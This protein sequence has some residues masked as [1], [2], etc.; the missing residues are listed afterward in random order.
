LETSTTPTASR[1]SRDRAAEL[2]EQAR[3]DIAAYAIERA[4]SRLDEASSALGDDTSLEASELTLRI[5]MSRTWGSF[6]SDPEGTRA[7][8][9]R[10]AAEATSSGLHHLVPLA[11]LQQGVLWTRLGEHV[12]A[13]SVLQRIGPYEGLLSLDD[14]VRLLINRGTT[15]SL[16]LRTEEASA[17]LAEAAALAKEAGL[18]RFAYM[19]LHNRGFVEFLRGDLPAAL[20]LM[21]E[22][23]RLDAP[24]DRGIAYLDR[25]RVLIEAGLVTD[26]WETLQ[27]ARTSLAESGL[28]TEADEVELDLA[29]CEV[30]LAR[31]DEAVARLAPLIERFAARAAQFRAIEARVLRA[32]ALAFGTRADGSAEAEALARDAA[33]VDQRLGQLAATLYAESLARTGRAGDAPVR[34]VRSVARSTQLARRCLARRVAVDLALAQGDERAARRTL[35][36]VSDDLRAARRG[37]SSLDLKTGM[38]LHASPLAVTDVALAAGSGSPARVLAVTERWRTATGSMP[39]VRPSDD[40]PEQALWTMLRKLRAEQ[41]DAAHEE[42]T[43]NR[44][45]VSRTVRA[46]RETSWAR[47][48]GRGGDDVPVST[49]Q[50]RTALSE[51]GAALT[52]MAVTGDRLVAVVARPGGRWR[53]VTVQGARDVLELARQ[54]AADLE[55]LAR[56]SSAVQG[57]A[58]RAGV[59]GSLMDTLAM[60]DRALAPAIPAG[61]EP[62]LLV[63]PAQL[64]AL[65]WAMLP[66]LRGRPVTVSLSATH[67]VRHAVAVADPVVR[68]VAGPDLRLAG[69]EQSAVAQAWQVNTPADL[70]DAGQA[71]DGGWSRGHDF[72]EALASADLVHVAAHGQHEPD[73]PLF[74]SLLLADGPTFVHEV[75]GMRIRARHVVLSACRAGRVNV[76]PGDEPLGLTACLLAFGVA[77]VV[78][79]VSIVGDELALTTM[80]AY[81]RALSSGLDAASALAAATGEG[82]LL[83]ASFTCFGAEWRA[84]GT[85][86]RR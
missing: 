18:D 47:D 23:D 14:R 71:R 86:P 49:S 15:A 75:E 24:V 31:G 3:G 20:R 73:N 54:V 55:A 27:T 42:L 74:S 80:T 41:R 26:A 7:T 68:A 69:A 46:L 38:A 9:D 70:G 58:L 85:G 35:R 50:I 8:L 82:P 11:M 63:P 32:E 12:R 84:S 40:P 4:M 5:T 33:A 39:Q 45:A 67:W 1:A 59:T 77:T 6:A 36:A 60:L 61:R 34:A 52:S 57:S 78:A 53:L 29:R 37:V 16:L 56:V 28:E 44:R 17:D 13:L 72:R 48:L 64:A 66:S 2:Y 25:G 10:V 21:D 62:L 83:A 76:R 19:A 51:R 43:E 22:A 65:P 30:L 79:P 81:H